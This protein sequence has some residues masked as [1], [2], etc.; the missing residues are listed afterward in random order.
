MKMLAKV[1]RIITVAPI[2]AFVLCTSI[3]AFTNAFNKIFI[4]FVC[5]ICLSVIP[6]LAYP[7]ENKT[8]IYA[9]KRPDLSK[10]EAQRAL[11]IIFSLIGYAILAV[12]IFSMDCHQILKQ[13]SLT[14]LLSGSFIFLLSFV[15]KINASGHAC[16]VAG[17]VALLTYAVSPWFLILLPLLFF[18]FWS[19]LKLKRHTPIQLII[20][21]AVPVVSLVIS[22][23]I[24]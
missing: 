14:Y 1:V 11:A 9:K 12:V 15:F 7:I 6:T 22:V 17:P 21:S 18:V 5:V 19:S 8:H 20:G 16:G 2:M 4:Y 3:L 23:L 24:V 13:M 10:R